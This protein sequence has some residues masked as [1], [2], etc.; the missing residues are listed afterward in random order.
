MVRTSTKRILLYA[1]DGKVV[2]A[3]FKIDTVYSPPTQDGPAEPIQQLATVLLEDGGPLYRIDN[4]TFETR[5]GERLTR[6]KPT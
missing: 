2:H 4:D 1:H 3:I 5:S 6:T